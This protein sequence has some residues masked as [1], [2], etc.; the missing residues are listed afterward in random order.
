MIQSLQPPFDSSLNGVITY[1][2]SEYQNW[3]DYV[4]VFP[5]TVNELEGR[6]EANC[7]INR[8]ILGTQGKDNWCSKNESN[9]YFIIAFP[10]FYLIPSFYTFKAKTVDT[11]S[12]VSWKVEGSID[13]KK[14]EII[15]RRD[16][17]SD[18]LERGSN[19]TYSFISSGVFRYFKFTQTKGNAESMINFCLRSFEIFGFIQMRLRSILVKQPL[20]HKGMIYIFLLC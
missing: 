7:L 17:I 20:L 18:L 11:M 14:W 6:D 8:S 4:S 19:K 3:Y 13:K 5:S 2:N 15:D 16:E 12:P 9:Q 10:K 1:L